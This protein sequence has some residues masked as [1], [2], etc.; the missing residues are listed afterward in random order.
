MSA[1]HDGEAPARLPAR[2]RT[3]D[4]A[5]ERI[6]LD[7]NA[8]RFRDQAANLRDAQLLRRIAAG[9]VI[10]RFMHHGTVNVIRAKALR[11]LGRRGVE[12][13]VR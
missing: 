7:R 1:A 10:N 3:H 11:H 4:L 6:A 13:A 2:R 9:R 5:I 8:A 12:L